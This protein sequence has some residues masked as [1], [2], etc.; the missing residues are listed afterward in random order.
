M[1]TGGDQFCPIETGG[2]LAS[3]NFAEFYRR[4]DTARGDADLPHL[5]K[6]QPAAIPPKFLPYITIIGVE[7]EGTRFVIRLAGS[8]ISDI[9]HVEMTGWEAD[10]SKPMQ[11]PTDGS[12]A[13]VERLKWSITHRRPY[14]MGGPARWSG[15]DMLTQRTLVLPYV[16]DDNR[17]ERFLT[18]NDLE[19]GDNSCESCEAVS[20]KTA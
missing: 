9:S 3:A 13:S 4:W 20:C 8:A 11:T 18:L 2:N 6:I 12:E 16:G 1:S 7:N 14:C 5:S 10:E 15:N 17:V 19:F